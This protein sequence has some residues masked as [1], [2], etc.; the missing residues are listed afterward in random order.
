MRFAQEKA[1]VEEYMKASS[2]KSL[3]KVDTDAL[4]VLEK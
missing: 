4:P 1:Q 2:K 3:K